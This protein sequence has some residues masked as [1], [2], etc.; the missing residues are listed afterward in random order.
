[1]SIKTY[2][3]F[4]PSRWELRFTSTVY[5]SEALEITSSSSIILRAYETER[6]KNQQT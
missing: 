2:E 5:R 1:M 3:N 4:S 6:R